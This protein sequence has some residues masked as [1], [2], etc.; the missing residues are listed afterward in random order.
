MMCHKAQ[1]WKL[2]KRQK[3]YQRF[4]AV[5]IFMRNYMSIFWALSLILR[6]VRLLT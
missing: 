1:D 2:E 3:N 4:K 5:S 6:A